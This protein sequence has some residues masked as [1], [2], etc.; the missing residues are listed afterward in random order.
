MVQAVWP[1]QEGLHCCTKCDAA[2]LLFLCRYVNSTRNDD[3]CIPGVSLCG[4][5][6]CPWQCCYVSNLAM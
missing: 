3:H 6:G 2:C 5:A 1:E 4:L